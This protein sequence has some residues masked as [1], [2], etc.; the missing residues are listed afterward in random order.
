MSL[1]PLIAAA[2]IAREN[3]FAPFSNFPVGAAIEAENGAIVT[4][5]NVESASYGLTMCAERVAICTAN[6][7]TGRWSKLWLR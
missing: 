2:A 6:S 4:G 7:F 5:C 1:D 3:A